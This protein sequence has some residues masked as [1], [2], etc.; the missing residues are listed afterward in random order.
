M[1]FVTCCV[2]EKGPSGRTVASM[3]HEIAMPVQLTFYVV[4]LDHKHRALHMYTYMYSSC[5]IP[6]HY[7]QKRPNGPISH[8]SYR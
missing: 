4:Y 5:Y 3:K 8:N 2:D 7:K 6:K 1:Q